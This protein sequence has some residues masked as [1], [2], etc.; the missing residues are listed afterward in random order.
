MDDVFVPYENP[1][2]DLSGLT[3]LLTCLNSARY[4]ISWGAMG[5]AES[6]W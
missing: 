2:P 3:S 4:G 1:F 6:C 5:V